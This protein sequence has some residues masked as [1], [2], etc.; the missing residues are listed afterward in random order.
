MP[1]YLS[2]SLPPPPPPPPFLP[3]R[4]GRANKFAYS[5]LVPF[6]SAAA[7]KEQPG[8]RALRHDWLL[9]FFI[10]KLES[11]GLFFPPLLFSETGHFFPLYFCILVLL[12]TRNLGLIGTAISST[13]A[14]KLI[15]I[16]G[17]WACV[18]FSQPSPV[19]L[20]P[21]SLFQPSSPSPASATRTHTHQK[22][23]WSV[24]SDMFLKNVKI[25]TSSWLLL[26]KLHVWQTPHIYQTCNLSQTDCDR[27]HASSALILAN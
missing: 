19:E 3:R 4:P 15:W 17:V 23:P 13:S 2:W 27:L 25:N 21:P 5:S 8:M 6:H 7:W 10:C 26:Q 1:I 16:A 24:P 18:F 20:L 14:L 11:R 9:C 12:Q 22:V